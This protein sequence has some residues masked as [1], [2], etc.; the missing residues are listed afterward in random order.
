MIERFRRF[1]AKLFDEHDP[2]VVGIE[3]PAAGGH[4]DVMTMNRQAKIA[5]MIEWAAHIKQLPC[6]SI[7]PSTWRKSFIGFGTRGKRVDVDWKKLAVARARVLGWTFPDHNAAE[8]GGILDNIAGE[9]LGLLTPWR[10]NLQHWLPLPE[11]IK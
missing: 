9:Q 10:E 5:G 2:Q 6:Y 7:S 11:I 1:L 3:A 8:A 4:G